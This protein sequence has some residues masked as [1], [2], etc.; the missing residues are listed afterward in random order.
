MLTTSGGR[1]LEECA[2]ASV[3]ASETLPKS[4][5]TLPMLTVR[6]WRSGAATTHEPPAEATP[7]ILLAVA[8][9]AVSSGVLAAPA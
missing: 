5:L 8:A 1:G 6:P 4:H 7:A 3:N 2:C 9:L